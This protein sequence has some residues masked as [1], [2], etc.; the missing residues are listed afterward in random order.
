MK[1]RA[2]LLDKDGTLLD[3][4]RTWVPINRD[5]ALFAA[6]GDVGLAGALLR[7]G[8]H[9]PTDDR[10]T[11]GSVLAAGSH[12]EVAAVFAAYLGARTPPR[13]ATE[14][15]RL[16]REGGAKH[17]TLMEGALDALDELQ[18]LG[19]AL[20]V[21]TNDSA[22]GLTASLERHPGLLDRFVFLAGCDS[23]FGVKPE[24]GMAL[25]FCRKLGLSPGEIAVVGDAVHDLEMGRRAGAGL[26]VGVLGGTST[27]DQLAPHADIV[28]ER[29]T[30]LP[31]RLAELQ[32]P[33][34]FD[35]SP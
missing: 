26:R 23:G 29:L 5:V 6:G 12:D 19:F 9:D 4:W 13:L 28:L 27:A 11:A 17:A 30:D 25:A 3:Y 8:G 15:E 33:P 32:V 34:Q 21:A 1:I 20:G 22:G 10:I 18:R 7:A 16:F 35:A 2:V 14:I 24:P 31:G